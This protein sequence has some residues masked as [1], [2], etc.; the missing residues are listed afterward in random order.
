[1][2]PLLHIVRNAI[3]HGLEGQAERLE[4]GKS[5]EGHL[6]LRAQTAGEVVII[7]IS[8]DG[9]GIDVDEIAARNPNTQLFDIDGKVD[10]PQ[11][12][13]IISTPGFSTR[14]QVDRA[15]GRGVGMD[16]VH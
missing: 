11:L 4:A 15:S 13:K 6:R 12:L 10:L 2:N 14:N 7:E 8:D 16:I 9:R 1:M 3:S 5:P